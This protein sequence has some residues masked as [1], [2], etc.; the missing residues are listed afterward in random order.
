MY[1]HTEG[2]PLFLVNVFNDLLGR[3][4]L[5]SHERGWTIRDDLSVD[6]LGIPSDV[7]RTIERQLDRLNDAE[8]R[9]LEVASA[10]GAT[11]SGATVATAADVPV[12]EVEVTLGALARRNAF[13][14]EGRAVTWPDGTVSTSFQFLHALYRDV[15]VKRLSAG[16]RMLLHRLIGLRLEAGYGERAA[17]RDVESRRR[18][19]EDFRAA[20]EISRTLGAKLLTLRASVSLTQ[21]LDCT[22]RRAEALAL[23]AAARRDVSEGG[24]LPDVTE[25]TALTAARQR[26]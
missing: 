6:S 23:L 2:N 3:G 21:L 12:D 14:R 18:A 15:L 7:R 5:F 13:I 1:E 20:I 22:T 8:R 10:A 17:S 26:S 19:E 25:A 4:I 9:L 16:R 24:D 11:F